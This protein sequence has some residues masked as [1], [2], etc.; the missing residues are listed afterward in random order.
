MLRSLVFGILLLNFAQTVVAQTS[1]QTPVAK[2]AKAGD[3]D[4]VTANR[5]QAITLAMHVYSEKHE[6][7]LPPPVIANPLL[8]PEDQ[9]S[10]FVLLLPHFGE[11]PG[12]TDDATWEKVRIPAAEAAQAK[13]LFESI[14]LK[15]AWNDP[16]NLA[17]AK[18]SLPVLTSPANKTTKDANGV[19]VSHFAFIRGYGGQDDGAFPWSMEVAVFD[20]TGKKQAISDGTMSTL[21]FGQ[22]HDHLGPWMAAGSSTSRFLFHPLERGESASFGSQYG[23]FCHVSKCDGHVNFMDIKNSTAIGLTAHVSRAGKDEQLLIG[24]LRNY[25][26]VAEWKATT[27]GK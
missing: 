2:K 7:M 4:E 12:S 8:K 20:P 9:L 15:K 3:A 16:A 1:P 24:N 5:L 27:K 21:A 13:N 19:A 17:A 11:K 10:G 23:D 14:D 26:N 22:I 6:F 18:T 25:K